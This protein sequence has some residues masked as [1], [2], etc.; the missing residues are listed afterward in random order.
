MFLGPAGS[1]LLLG[2]RCFLWSTRGYAAEA[3]FEDHDIVEVLTPKVVL[4]ILKA[5]YE[6]DIDETILALL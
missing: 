2:N 6:P 3:A 1:Y 5:G 4:G